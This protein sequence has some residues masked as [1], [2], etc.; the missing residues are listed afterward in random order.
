MIQLSEVSLKCESEDQK[1]N[2]FCFMITKCTLF[3]LGMISNCIS[4]KEM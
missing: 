2:L 3:E 4:P 1:K